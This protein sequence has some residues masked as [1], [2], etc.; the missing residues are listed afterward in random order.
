MENEEA[1]EVLLKNLAIEN[2]NKDCQKVLL[3][4]FSPTLLEMVD[5]Y[6]KIGTMQHQC[7]MMASAF[8]AMKL[9][10]QHSFTCGRLGHLCWNCHNKKAPG[11]PVYLKCC[12]EWHVNQCHSCFAKGGQSMQGNGSESVMGAQNDKSSRSADINY[13]IPWV[14]LATSEPVALHS[15]GHEKQP[16]DMPVVCYQSLKPWQGKTCLMLLFVIT[17]MTFLWQP[18]QLKKCNMPW[19]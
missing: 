1:W 18:S 8:T 12:I 3:P 16:H 2:A 14:D 7:N 10:S 19:L 5:M 13:A 17:W 6:S 4:L 9:N 15:S 11:P